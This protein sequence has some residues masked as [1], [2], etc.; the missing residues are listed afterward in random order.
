MIARFQREFELVQKGVSVEST[1]SHPARAGQ[2]VEKV[3]RWHCWS[4]LT[5]HLR[6][7][8]RTGVT[9]A[10]ANHIR[11]AAR[12]ATWQRRAIVGIWSALVGL[13]LKL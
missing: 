5:E 4:S 2:S 10:T 1:I 8:L 6:L 7:Y 9:P 13:P 3:W 11:L 12:F